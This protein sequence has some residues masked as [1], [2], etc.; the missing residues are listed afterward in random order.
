MVHALAGVDLSIGRGEFVAIMGPSGSGKSTA[1]NILGCLDTPTLGPLPLSR[2]RCRPPRPRQRALLRRNYLGFVFQGY[3]LLA[4]TTR[5]RE[6]RAAADLSR[7]AASRAARRRCEA[8]RRGRA[9]RPRTSHAGR[10]VGRPA[11]ARRDRP[12]HRRRALSCCS[13]T[14]RPAISTPPR[15]H[16]IMEL[17][18]KL[19]DEQGSPSSWSRMSP[20]WR[21]SRIAPSASSTVTS[22]PISWRRCLMIWEALKLALQSVRRNPLRSVLTLLGIVIGVAAVI[23]MV[24]IG[25]GTTRKGRGRSRQARQQPAGRARRRPNAS[26]R[27]AIRDRAR[28]TIATSRPLRNGLHAMCAPSRRVSRAQPR[29]VFGAQNYRTDSD[30]HRLRL[31]HRARLELRDAAAPSP[32]AKCAAGSAVCVI[33]E[34]VKRCCSAPM[35][36]ARRAHPRRQCLLRGHRRARSA[37]AS[38]RFGTDQDNIVIMPLARLPAAHRRQHATSRRSTSRSMP[39]A[40]DRAPSRPTS[41]RIL[42]ERRRIAPGEDDDFAVRDMTQIVSTP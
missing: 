2:R 11:A 29:I 40:A 27:A 1:M 3:N 38:R 21:P 20:T 22:T 25:D 12:R 6:C 17:L 32:T 30:R 26:A 16:E 8:L 5:G 31:L 7:R 19:N 10:T 18:T 36:P 39:T 4:R 35:R 37:R 24:T 14:S 15:S 33:G 28:S 42:R 9:R 34:T 41:R 23:A 13:P